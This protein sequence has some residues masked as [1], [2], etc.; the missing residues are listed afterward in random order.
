MYHFQNN[1]LF[2]PQSLNDLIFED[3]PPSKDMI[4]LHFCE[5][6]YKNFLISGTFICLKDVDNKCHIKCDK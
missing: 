6:S 5:F 3:G 2:D 1:S 4:Y